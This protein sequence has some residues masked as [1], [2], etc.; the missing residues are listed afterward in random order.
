MATGRT[1]CLAIVAAGILSVPAFAQT[2]TPSQP[3]V[4]LQK[5]IG[6]AKTVVVPSLLVLNAR[7]ASLQGGK[8]ALTGVSPDTI[9]FA[10]RPA[11]AAGHDLTAHIIED[12][13]K[14]AQNFASDPPNATVSRIGKDDGNI[15]DAVVVLRTP[16]LEGDQLTFDVDVLEGDLT[17]ADGPAAVFID[18][19]NRPLTARRGAWYARAGTYGAYAAPPNSF[20]YGPSGICG[21]NSPC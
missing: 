19:I 1:L 7:G 5:T 11:R 16:K 2:P 21:P 15:R 14:G 8:L 4:P 13:G 10:D 3:H 18:D 6:H 17:G 20:E 12:W 9:V